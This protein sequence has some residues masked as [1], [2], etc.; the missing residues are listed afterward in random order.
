MVATCI[1]TASMRYIPIDSHAKVL[2]VPPYLYF[3][4]LL[5]DIVMLSFDRHSLRLEMSMLAARVKSV[6]SAHD[7]TSLRQAS[8]SL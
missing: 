3:S 6:E 2:S 4:A 5:C 8:V 1:Q 7:D